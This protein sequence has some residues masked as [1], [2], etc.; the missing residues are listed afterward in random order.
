MS[1]A[2]E[3]PPSL[4]WLGNDG[5][6]STIALQ[7]GSQKQLVQV[8]PA[9]SGSSVW[10]VHTQGC[11][12]P[13]DP[14]LVADPEDC[15]DLRGGLFSPSNNSFEEISRNDPNNPYFQLLF[16]DAE[17]S[18]GY[19]GTAIL[20][21]DDFCFGS[22]PCTDA[23]TLKDQVV[24]TY[25]DEFPYIGQLGISAWANHVRYANDTDVSP[26]ASMKADGKIPSLFYGYTAGARYKDPPAFASL[27]FGG[28]DSS[29]GN[30]EERRITVPFGQDNT[31]DLLVAIKSV[32]IGG[33]GSTSVQVQGLDAGITAMI[34]SLVP[35]IYL[36]EAACRS[37]ESAFGLVYNETAGYYLV[38]D[39][40]HETLI[41]QD[42]SISFRLAPD[43]SST[44]TVDINLPYAAFDLGLQY[45]R[46]N[47]RDGAT[48]LRYFPLQRA[49]TS[50]QQFLGRTFLQEAY[51]AADYEKRE[52][53]VS[54]ALVPAQQG[55]KNL[56]TVKGGTEVEDASGLST[57]AIAGIA[58]AG[59][60]V[61]I[62]I[63]GALF[64]LWFRRRKSRR[65][66]TELQ[67]SVGTMFSRQS[68]AGTTI[69][70][71]PQ[72]ME[73]F[74]PMAPPG[75]NEDDVKPELDATVTARGPITSYHRHEL[76]A[77]SVRRTSQQTGISRA[78]IS[79][80]E[81]RHARS[82]SY[83][84]SMGQPSPGGEHSP[85]PAGHPSP[86]MSD[87]GI[88]WFSNTG[89]FYELH[90]NEQAMRN[91]QAGPELRQDE[92]LMSGVADPE[93]GTLPPAERPAPLRTPSQTRSPTERPPVSPPAGRPTIE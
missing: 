40:Q 70:E 4:Y 79:P 54:Q 86:P 44:Q 67:S 25:A 24:A 5:N 59:T 15:V 90:A 92:D 35:E 64:W 20:G 48:S 53:Y 32:T 29:R 89:P 78:T 68:I 60:A 71:T 58:I 9:T 74:K 82:M 63:L 52:F 19:N 23:T 22:N 66:Q 65:Q 3:I 7:L 57:G 34:D 41:Q 11:Q 8:L 51:L 75:M 83:G 93:E 39:T 76:S 28:Y 21:K 80:I 42:K 85:S 27:T 17:A 6:W 46:A 73:F 87:R 77:G 84:S 14:S 31:R 18:L 2:I 33:N 61:V 45:P 1:K 81:N 91:G 16:S 47:I 12:F 50:E 36:P 88:S 37:F 62:M 26:L 72:N 55:T 69:N 10:A 43:P 30:D 49:Q 56:I 38:N 13:T